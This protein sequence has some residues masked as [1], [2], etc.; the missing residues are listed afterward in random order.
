MAYAR[1]GVRTTATDLTCWKVKRPRATYSG[2][3]VVDG[4]V[5]VTEAFA[6]T[7]CMDRQKQHPD[8]QPSHY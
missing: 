7:S 1:L 8:I 3:A 6:T 4:L 2:Q 5:Y